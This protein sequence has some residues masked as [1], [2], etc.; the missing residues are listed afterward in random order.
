MQLLED[1]HIKKPKC[2]CLRTEDKPLGLVLQ[3]VQELRDLSR[4]GVI[5]S[6]VVVGN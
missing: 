3:S 2:P 4:Y 6:N 1:N 5:K